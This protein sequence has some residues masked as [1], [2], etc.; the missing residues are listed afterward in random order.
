MQ[1]RKDNKNRA[2][3]F[4]ALPCGFYLRTYYLLL[5]FGTVRELKY[6][7]NHDTE[8]DIGVLLFNKED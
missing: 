5:I 6:S 7:K 3:H 4:K 8:T 1:N 2:A